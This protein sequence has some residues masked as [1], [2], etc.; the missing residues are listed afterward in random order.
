MNSSKWIHW[1]IVEQMVTQNS[2]MPTSRQNYMFKH[3]KLWIGTRIYI[4]YFCI[5]FIWQVSCGPESLFLIPNFW[6][7]GNVWQLMFHIHC[8]KVTLK[9][10]TEM[11]IAALSLITGPLTVVSDI[12]PFIGQYISLMVCSHSHT[13][14]RTSIDAN[15]AI[16]IMFHCFVQWM[17]SCKQEQPIRQ[18][19]SSLLCCCLQ[20]LRHCYRN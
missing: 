5:W 18:A 13:G 12:I 15:S 14:L 6:Y 3:E 9:L 10:K 19:Q 17:Q 11:R 1:T 4:H 2:Y 20:S 8:F 7:V 16:M